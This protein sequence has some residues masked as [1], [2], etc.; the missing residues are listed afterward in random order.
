MKSMNN[1][2][3]QQQALPDERLTKNK[4]RAAKFSHH[5]FG[6]RRIE[7]LSNDFSTQKDFNLFF[8]YTYYFL[9]FCDAL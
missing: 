7:K 8:R 9:D 4:Y 1:S 3:G 5:Y 2:M 6:A